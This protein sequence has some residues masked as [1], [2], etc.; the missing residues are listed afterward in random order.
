MK[1]LHAPTSL[2]E[3]RHLELGTLNS[4]DQ[5]NRSALYL[6]DQASTS[7]HGHSSD[8]WRTPVIK[9]PHIDFSTSALFAYNPSPP[10]RQSLLR[11]VP[12]TLPSNVSPL[13][14]WGSEPTEIE[15]TGLSGLEDF[16]SC[17]KT[18]IRTLPVAQPPPLKR[19]RS[20]EASPQDRR[21]NATKKS[22][23]AIPL[24]APSNLPGPAVS[25]K[26][27]NAALS[28][29]QSKSSTKS[30][31]PVRLRLGLTKRTNIGSKL[32][33][34]RPSDP[35]YGTSLEAKLAHRNAAVPDPPPKAEVGPSGA[36][37][38]SKRT[39][40]LRV[41][42][43]ESTLGPSMDEKSHIQIPIDP[44][45]PNSFPSSSL[46]E[47]T[48]RRCAEPMGR[49]LVPSSPSLSTDR[50]IEV[51]ASHRYDTGSPGLCADMPVLLDGIPEFAS[52]PSPKAESTP[53][54]L[55]SPTLPNS[56]DWDLVME[57][58]QVQ[59]LCGD[60]SGLKSGV[61]HSDS[62]LLSLEKPSLPNLSNR[63]GTSCELT[64]LEWRHFSSQ[65]N[66][67]ADLDTS[68]DL[69]LNQLMGSVFYD[70]S[71]DSNVIQPDQVDKSL[72]SPTNVSLNTDEHESLP[73]ELSPME[74]LDDFRFD[75]D[76]NLDSPEFSP[77]VKPMDA[78]GIL[79]PSNSGTND[80]GLKQSGS[81]DPGDHHSNFGM[82]SVLYDS[83]QDSPQLQDGEIA[84]HDQRNQRQDEHPRVE[85]TSILVPSWSSDMSIR[86]CPD[87][88]LSGTRPVNSWKPFSTCGGGSPD[89]LVLA[90]RSLSLEDPETRH[91]SNG[92]SQE[93][94]SAQL[95]S[96]A[97]LQPSV[98]HHTNIPAGS[99]GK[100]AN[101]ACSSHGFPAPTNKRSGTSK[102]AA[103]N[104]TA[105][106]LVGSC[107]P[108]LS[109]TPLPKRNI[110][111]D[112][113]ESIESPDISQIIVTG[114]PFRNNPIFR[115]PAA[116]PTAE[117]EED[118]S[119][120]SQ[121]FRP[122]IRS[123][124]HGILATSYSAPAFGK[125]TGSKETPKTDL[126]PEVPSSV[127]V[128][129]HDAR[130]IF[131]NVDR[132]EN[133]DT[134]KIL[135]SHEPS[136][137]PDHPPAQQPRPPSPL[138]SKIYKGHLHSV[139]PQPH[140]LPSLPCPSPSL[141]E[142]MLA[143]LVPPSFQNWLNQDGSPAQD[144]ASAARNFLSDTW[145]RAAW[146][147]PVRGRA[148]WE[149]CS[150]AM[151]SL[152]PI[153]ERK[154]RIIVWTPAALRSFWTQMA[155]FRDTKRVGP[156]SMSFEAA[157][158]KA[159]Q[160]EGHQE[161]SE[162]KASRSFEFIKLYHDSRVSLKLRTILQVLEFADEDQHGV[163]ATILKEEETG[164]VAMRRLLGASTRLAL[165]DSTGNIVLVS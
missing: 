95:V 82:K 134:R 165:L 105:G 111:D 54:F 161:A 122:N 3:I 20:I 90:S 156:L 41:K 94:S 42:T 75:G 117:P 32:I 83:S 141:T 77:V 58:N 5:I 78:T 37:S 6:T 138:I 157:P 50:T 153:K 69:K 114:K 27:R 154:K 48:S 59:P 145:G 43:L 139:I 30:N 9:R 68:Y 123:V 13:L 137:A 116:K 118:I 11:I 125:T 159:P 22:R 52:L 132:T 136:L 91:P 53:G 66:D 135:Q 112:S 67:T 146:I 74:D 35:P 49:V 101:S 126:T 152:R 88:P 131:S 150:G 142:G 133:T 8:V 113:L 151:V 61:F 97:P 148:P 63:T 24:P 115:F 57:K 84:F 76:H 39:L 19:R 102:L 65:P 34:K 80:H 100:A 110:L 25:A 103:Y 29:L 96:Q 23:F 7:N 60:L 98:V 46:S 92:Q 87:Y 51:P 86:S 44:V 149:G 107:S 93:G 17:I 89:D 106:S 140:F 127:G 158:D 4:D 40:V 85:D 64:L 55:L 109:F 81:S 56:S 162:L 129:T 124:S 71:Q 163:D 73:W 1:S 21:P 45:V 62:L 144:Q 160:P 10:N 36:N 26:I 147:I 119:C 104:N 28:V 31:I 120:E 16:R 12:L 121:D 33:S 18:Y 15:E 130:Q 164:T 70:S 38:S 2:T 99:T 128:S 14:D 108:I 143:S 155:G 72:N 47:A 79:G